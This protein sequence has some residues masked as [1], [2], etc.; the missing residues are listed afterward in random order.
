MTR[1]HVGISAAVAAAGEFRLSAQRFA[2]PFDLA[3]EAARIRNWIRVV[4]R[5]ASADLMDGMPWIAAYMLRAACSAARAETLL[6]E[7]EVGGHLDS[8]RDM[9]LRHADAEI[10][11]ALRWIGEVLV[12][13]DDD[14]PDPDP[15]RRRLRRPLVNQIDAVLDQKL[16]LARQYARE[17]RFVFAETRTRIKAA[18][19]RIWARARYRPD[20]G[21]FFVPD[22]LLG[23]L[24][25]R[26]RVRSCQLVVRSR[27]IRKATSATAHT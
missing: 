16:A 11:D 15:R 25:R 5:I 23:R 4:E 20:P 18:R 8:H 17:G 24:A 13:V 9:K 2:D 19:L 27:F 26:R 12:A 1:S 21:R 3:T 10:N 6:G 14:D 7:L 22:G